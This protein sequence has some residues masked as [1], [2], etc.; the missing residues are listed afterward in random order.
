MSGSG[1]ISKDGKGDTRHYRILSAGKDVLYALDSLRYRPYCYED[2][3]H[4]AR[5][6]T[7]AMSRGDAAA[8]CHLAGYGVHAD[9][10]PPLPACTPE[11]TGEDDSWWMGVC[12]NRDGA[13]RL[14]PVNC[15]YTSL[16]IKRH[17]GD[18]KAN[19][20]LY[21]RA[22]GI[23]LT[24]TRMLRVYHSRDVAMEVRLTGERNLHSVTPRLFTGLQPPIRNALLVMGKKFFAAE[25]IIRNSVE[26][27]RQQSML[28]SGVCCLTADVLGQP[29]LYLPVIPQAL[30][31]FRLLQYP[32]Y[33]NSIMKYAQAG[34]NVWNGIDMD[35]TAFASILR[36]K[37]GNTKLLL[38]ILC[39]DWQRG[40]Y[41]GML[42]RYANAANVSFQMLR[43]KD[44][45]RIGSLLANYW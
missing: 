9:D 5:R 19:S 22:C 23:L 26:P 7:R 39:T 21:S 37:Q 2:N 20:L 18:K 17:F 24:P 10:K 30:P 33:T 11:P 43:D 13:R 15:Y 32:G 44:M 45:E 6:S 38:S 34:Q 29:L 28:V 40:F 8:V 4:L 31:V 35:L 3:E 16:E 14:T 42:E 1:L 12:R 36:R 41:I 25:K 27:Q